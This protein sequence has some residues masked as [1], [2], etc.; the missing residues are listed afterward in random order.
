MGRSPYWAA[1]N[2]GLWFQRSAPLGSTFAASAASSRGR[3]ARARG[4]TARPGRPPGSAFRVAHRTAEPVSIIPDALPRARPDR[5]SRF[6]ACHSGRCPSAATPTRRPRAGSSAA[7]ARRGSTSSTPPTSTTRAA[8]RRSSGRLLRGCR[9]EV[10]LASKAHFPT[11]KG[12]NDRGSSRYHLVRAVE[13]SLRRLATDRID[14]YYLHRFD[15]Q[16]DGRREPARAGRSGP[17]GQDPLPGLLELRRLA[18]GPRPGAG[19]AAAARAAGGAAADVQPAQAPGRGGD[20]ARWP[21]PSAWPSCR[22]A[23]PRAAS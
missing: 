19:G 16:T 15:D 10:V 17:P 6:R 9:D 22:T 14:V 5:A 1:I 4:R 3:P 18:G 12:P 7:R 2:S 23:R 20:P 21:E 11:G 13:A 8:R